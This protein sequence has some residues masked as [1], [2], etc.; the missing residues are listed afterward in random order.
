M[1]SHLFNLNIQAPAHIQRTQVSHS[2]ALKMYKNTHVCRFKDQKKK[3]S[4]NIY[5][6]AGL[7]LHLFLILTL[8]LFFNL[9]ILCDVRP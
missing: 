9:V 2:G 8:F 5:T 7:F 1:T 6:P 3:L 4:R